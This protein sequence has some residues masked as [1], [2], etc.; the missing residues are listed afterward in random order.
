[1][2]AFGFVRKL[3]GL[4]N[5]RPADPLVEVIVLSQNDP[6]TGLRVMRS[7]EAHGLP[8]SRAIFT[9]GASPHEYIGA[10]SMSL[11]LSANKKNVDDAM[12]LGF[13]AGLVV[14]SADAHVGDDTVK[15]ALDFD[16]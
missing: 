16:G 4:N 15:V 14:D 13:P 7:V 8:I 9:Q 3:L 10:L 1:G 5:L 2:V 6:S 12:A 11:F